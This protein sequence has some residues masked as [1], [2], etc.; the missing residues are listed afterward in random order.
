MITFSNK[1]GVLF[2]F[3]LHH[4]NA[5]SNS[6]SPLRDFVRCVSL[7]RPSNT[8]GV[9]AHELQPWLDEPNNADHF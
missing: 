4:E 5:I 3:T 7:D 2:I 6:V 1:G 8:I 9:E